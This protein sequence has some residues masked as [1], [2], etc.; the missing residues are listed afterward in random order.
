MSACSAAAAAAAPAAVA[1]AA[2]V[3]DNDTDDTAATFG[4]ASDAS[5]A[6][7]TAYVFKLLLRLL[8]R[9]VTLLQPHFCCQ[10]HFFQPL[11][12]RTLSTPIGLLTLQRC[13]LIGS[14]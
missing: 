1:A 11:I 7:N 10:P 9:A 3:A 6:A 8:L 13:I 4:A 14:N 12:L 2:P 5:G